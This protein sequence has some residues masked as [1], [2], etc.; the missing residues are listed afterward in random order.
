VISNTF[1][2][3]DVVTLKNDKPNKGLLAGDRGTL[4]VNLGLGVWEVEFIYD[5]GTTKALVALAEK[6]FE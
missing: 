3:L 1:N 6:E 4:V 2:L 5:D